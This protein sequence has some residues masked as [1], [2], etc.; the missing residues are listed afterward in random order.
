MEKEVIK[1]ESKFIK[2]RIF[3]MLFALLFAV[4]L[5]MSII[6]LAETKPFKL[7]TVT[8]SDKSEGVTGSISS[9]NDDEIINDITF[10]KLNDYVT[11]NLGIKSN[12]SNEITILD[13]T[14]DNSNEYIA[15]EYDKHENEKITSGSSLNLD[16]KIIYKKEVTDISKRKQ[17]NNVN[18]L[19]KYLEEGNEKEANININ[20]KTGDNVHISYILLGISAI[21]LTLSI[22]LDKKRKNK[23]L[24]KITTFIITG[25]LLSPVIVNAETFVHKITLK[26][27][28]NLYDKI[29]VTIDDKVN[30]V[31]TQ[32]IEYNT[33]IDS[34]PNT[35]KEGYTLTKWIVN[36]EDFDI[37][38][39]IKEDILVEAVYEANEYDIVFNKNANEATGTMDNK[40]MKYD[41]KANLPNNVFERY[42]HSFDSWNT[43]PDGSGTKYED[44]AEVKN[45]TT[46][47]NGI[48]NLY[49][50]WQLKNYTITFD[51]NSDDATGT[52]DSQIFTY[53]DNVT[54]NE[55]VFNRSKYNFTGWNTMP[56]GSG[57]HYDNKQDIT[58]LID[59]DIT[60][61]A[62][63][64]FKCKGFA[65]DSWETIIENINN[66]T[67]YYQVSSSCEREIEMDLDDDGVKESYTVRLV[68]STTPTVCGTS[69]YS[70]TACG[71]VLEFVDIVEYRKMNNT[72]TNAGG[73][74]D[75]ALAT[76][77]NGEFYNKLPSDLR[78]VII[79]TYPIVSGSGYTTTSANITAA[80][81]TKNKIYLFSSLEV[82]QDQTSDNKRNPNT[83]TRKLDYYTSS[84]SGL[85]QKTYN[86]EEATWWLR[87]ADTH[88][89]KNFL[90]VNS[91]G[92]NSQGAAAGESGVVPAFRIGKYK[93]SALNGA[94]PVLKSDM[95]PVIINDNGTVTKASTS[96]QWYSYYNKKWANT[97]V[98]ND[99]TEYSV[100][101]VI[102]ESK[103]KAHYVWIPRYRYRLFNN[104]SP[105]LITIVFENKDTPKS[106]GTITNLYRTHP[107]F[108][109]GDEEL[110]GFWV[111]KFEP[112]AETSSACYTASS[113]AN[114][115]SVQIANIKPNVISLRNQQVVNA[116]KTS[117]NISNGSGM[118]KND[119]WGA[120]TYLSHS[121]IGYG[122]A[123]V[124]I[125][126]NNAFITGCG[127][128]SSTTEVTTAACEIQYGNATSYPQST[129]GNITGVF[130]MSGG[131]W[132]YMMSVRADENG[133]ALSGKNYLH[134]SGFNG[135]FGDPTSDSQTATA[136]TTGENFPD[137]K[138]YI[139]YDNPSDRSNVTG[140]NA[141]NGQK[142]YGHALTEIKSGTSNGWYGD[143]YRS[144]FPASTAGW[145][146]R[147]GRGNATNTANS[148]KGNVGIFDLDHY[149]GDAFS[150][151]SFRAV[152]R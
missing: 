102:P 23:K 30:P 124:R 43:M 16:V 57:T 121:T 70:Q 147:G 42:G 4:S 111:G 131:A 74:K 150:T 95:V 31:T 45:L 100:G 104:A 75:S 36:N 50:Q 99:N 60:L 69:G 48:V 115:N 128:T 146:M 51:R 2:T 55:N 82:G 53:G 127:A 19:I 96:E 68:N 151:I 17:I 101:D 135:K 41:E 10:H 125:N 85:R 105:S 89:D 98:L 107:A 108:T 72:S 25:L 63:W 142:C 84:T 71:I 58:N 6:A 40:H 37:T 32:T 116:Y 136:L 47:S 24:S 86:N 15:Y 34:L 29:V 120:V 138:N 114:C 143:F 52:M 141:C 49:A 140:D 122:N 103:I 79:P 149:T 77:L 88:T 44:G 132:E 117:L 64:V 148:N 66:D 22:S 65:T 27:T 134:N 81:T 83:D 59:E 76:Y 94:D 11:F 54:L 110:N 61:Y 73:W 92:N 118:M 123:R 7:D 20:P 39:E 144:P 145:I 5:F 35:T 129:T 8:I 97:V 38:K 133:I 14:D 1:K 33:K 62:E 9:F 126:N 46:T 56:D 13:I 112:S 26:S 28:I 67:D 90:I 18:F 137:A 93:E 21:G 113:V 119:E 80:D 78:E 87:S 3:T 12:L 109:Y 152:V 106:T 139:V 130:D 91:T